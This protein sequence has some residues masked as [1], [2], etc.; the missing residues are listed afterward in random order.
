[1]PLHNM[2]STKGECLLLGLALS[3]VQ[4]AYATKREALKKALTQCVSEAKPEAGRVIADHEL[5]RDA[6]QSCQTNPLCSG[7]LQD[8][9]E[10]SK[11]PVFWDPAFYPALTSQAPA[12]AKP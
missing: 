6:L 3:Y 5:L 1:M 10:L 11:S 2:S 9:A 4:P 7:L 8:L 12:A